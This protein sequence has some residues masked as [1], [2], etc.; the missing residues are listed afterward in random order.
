MASFVDCFF[1]YMQFVIVF[2]SRASSGPSFMCSG[3][4]RNANDELSGI[5]QESLVNLYLSGA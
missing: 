3:P 4:S 5:K 2:N 1:Y